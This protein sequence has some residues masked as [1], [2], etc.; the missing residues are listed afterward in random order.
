MTLKA[1]DVVVRGNES[2]PAPPQTCVI[3]WFMLFDTCTN[4]HQDAGLCTR[5][6]GAATSTTSL[7]VRH[8][9]V[10]MVVAF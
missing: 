7:G 10:P 6:R 5:T 1:E 8:D 4:I 2:K 9:L 3:E